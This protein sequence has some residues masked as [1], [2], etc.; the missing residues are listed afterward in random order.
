MQL[1]ELCAAQEAAATRLQA[2]QRGRMERNEG[3]MLQAKARAHEQVA[4]QLEAAGR[5]AEAAEMR[6][7]AAATRR[8][9]TKRT[10]LVRSKHCVG[11][12]L[13]AIEL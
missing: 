6:K 7:Q 2:L 10:P 1:R 12:S 13:S 4:A 5:A 11:S 8:V 9:A 3:A